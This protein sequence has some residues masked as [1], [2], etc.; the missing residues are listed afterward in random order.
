MSRTEVRKV[1]TVATK[2][3]NEESSR[4]K[5]YKSRRKTMQEGERTRKKKQEV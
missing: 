2:I 3:K 5:R 4:K 1:S